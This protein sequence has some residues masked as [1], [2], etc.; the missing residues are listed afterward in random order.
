MRLDDSEMAT[1][2]ELLQ[3]LSD[4]Q[5]GMDALIALAHSDVPPAEAV[6]ALLDCT[7][8]FGERTV[9]QAAVQLLGKFGP[10]AS[11]AVPYLCELLLAYRDR[12][13]GRHV[14]IALGR[15][16]EASALRALG[17][18]RHSKL[19]PVRNAARRAIRQIPSATQS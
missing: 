12:L 2:A 10:A 7:R 14:A 4:P 3:Q 11:I 6:P 16:G 18:A 13:L 15:I 1:T 8:Y 9:G 17:E 5:R 19:S